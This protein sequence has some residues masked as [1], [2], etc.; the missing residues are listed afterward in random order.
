MFS[1]TLKALAPLFFVVSGLHLTLGIDADAL[2]GARV[3]PDVSAEPSLDSQSRFFGVAFGLY[4]AILYLCATDLRRF[5]PVF[6]AAMGVF[7]LGGCARLVSWTS[8][9][10]PAP[11]VV[12]LLASELLVPPILL[13]WQA[14]VMKQASS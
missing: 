14:R 9:G 6:K 13:V 4:G 8:H 5:E 1:R 10:M 12:V 11:M 2:L 3:G 7:F